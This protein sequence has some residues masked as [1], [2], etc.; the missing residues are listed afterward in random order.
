MKKLWELE[1]NADDFYRNRTFSEF[2]SHK[3]EDFARTCQELENKKEFQLANPRE[4]TIIDM[5]N[6]IL[7]EKRMNDYLI[8]LPLIDTVKENHD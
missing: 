5:L 7:G 4:D 3:I 2:I 8:M 1:R 6:Q